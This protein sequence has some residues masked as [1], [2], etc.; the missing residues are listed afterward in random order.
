[1]LSRF[2]RMQLI[3]FTIAAVIGIA[4]M[5][6]GYMQVPTLLGIGRITVKLEL[7]SAGGLYRFSNV[8]YRGVEVGTVTDVT[9]VDG[10]HVEATLS[11]ATSPK[12]PANLQAKVRNASA[13]GEQYV[14]LQPPNDAP[15]YLHDGSVIGMGQTRIPEPV[16]PML[17]RLNLL[18]E[19][20][21]K[22][23]LGPLLDESFKAF[24]GAGYD[25]GS[26][27]DSGSKITKD[28]N[29]VADQSRTLADDSVPLLDSQAET[30]DSTRVW[31]RNLAGITDQFTAH[32]GQVR[33]LLQDGSGFAQEVSRL[34]EQVKPTLPVL[35]AN[36]T[37]IGQV[38]V[39]YNKSVEQL[40]VL[41]PPYL[42]GLQSV[43][44]V[45]NPTGKPMGD[46][47]L[48]VS[49][50]PSCTVGFLPPS[51]WRSPAD[52]TDLDTPDGLYCKLPQDS[53]IDV[54]G[55]RN[56]PCVEHP[57]KRAA[58]VQECNSDKG[59]QPLAM[60]QHATGPYPFDPNLI[61]Q[62]IP[63]DRRADSGTTLY[64]PTEGTPLPA[65]DAPPPTDPPGQLP[66]AEPQPEPASGD[67]G[68]PA[69]A[70]SSFTGNGSGPKPSVATAQYNPQTGA[71][72][73]SDGH[74]Y[75][76]SNLVTAK[77]PTSWTDLMPGPG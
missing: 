42:A 13:V 23:E 37:S 53:P 59:F 69:V 76:Q 71:Y 26:L 66:Q 43:A 2:V 64:A 56:F 22:D 19:S 11:L 52:T 15:P 58:T 51:E 67:P 38:L 4:V 47:A 16:G 10:R 54:R 70:P 9:T 7:P 14:D 55:A 50:P 63:P 29:E 31:A 72:M 1:M 3:I 48:S 33:A 28:L 39:T 32:D 6:T 30:T 46:F 24:N 45:N 41:F 8:T 57:G 35:L 21:P 5:L 20:I 77:V 40:L 36:L 62:G 61:R 60:R 65:A 74:L 18:V 75:H 73:A 12:I 44:P 49:D 17:D 25:I 27:I 68:A 34:L